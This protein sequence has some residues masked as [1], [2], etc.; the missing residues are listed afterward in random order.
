MNALDGLHHNGTL[1]CSSGFKRHAR[2][3]GRSDRG[4]EKHREGYLAMACMQS[5]PLGVNSCEVTQRTTEDSGCL[6][7]RCTSTSKL[8]PNLT[9]NVGIQLSLVFRWTAFYLLTSSWFPHIL[10]AICE[11]QHIGGYSQA[12]SAP[13]TTSHAFL[14]WTERAPGTR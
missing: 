10:L 12:G 9:H 4:D 3:A 13:A 8:S 6:A 7:S 11:H 1:P 14:G 2:M 5:H